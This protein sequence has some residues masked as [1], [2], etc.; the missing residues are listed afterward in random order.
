MDLFGPKVDINGPNVDLFGLSVLVLFECGKF[1]RRQYRLRSYTVAAPS[2]IGERE[3]KTLEG[4]RK[5]SKIFLP[6]PNLIKYS[7]MIRSYNLFWYYLFRDTRAVDNCWNIPSF[8][9]ELVRIT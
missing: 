1:M 5:F 3:V 2:S 9:T 8:P 7:K 4:Q 6:C